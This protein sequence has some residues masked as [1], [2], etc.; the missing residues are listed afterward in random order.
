MRELINWIA[1]VLAFAAATMVLGWWGVPAV[2]ALW[3]LIRNPP[4]IYRWRAAA[5]AAAI[6]WAGLLAVALVKDLGVVVGQ[7]D[8]LLRLPALAIAVLTVVFPA[9]L[10]GSAAEL[11]YVVRT[12]VAAYRRSAEAEG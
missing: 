2:G 10:A 8:G 4:V 9:F 1:L 5:A 6:A 11:A 7:L 3:G 12:A